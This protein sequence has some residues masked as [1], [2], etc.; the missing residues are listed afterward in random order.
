[1]AVDAA[2]AWLAPAFCKTRVTSASSSD[3]EISDIEKLGERLFA[4]E[5][6]DAISDEA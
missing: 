4:Q 5:R 1:L 3:G 6:S 2:S